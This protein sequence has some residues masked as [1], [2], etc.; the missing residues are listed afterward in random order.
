MINRR[1]QPARSIDAPHL[2]FTLV[3]LLVVIA[4]IGILIAL[5]LPAVQSAR[6]AARRAQCVNALKQIGLGMHNFH[7]ARGKFPHGA[8]SDMAPLG[9]ATQESWGCAWT[10]WVLPYIEGQS[11]YDRLLFGEDTNGAVNNNGSGWF[12]PYNYRI[13]GNTTVPVYQCPSSPITERPQSGGAFG[14]PWL[15]RD[16]MLNHFAGI[17]GFG[18]PQTGTSEFTLVGFNESRKTR[19]QFGVSSSGGILFAGGAIGARKILDGTSKTLMV[20]EQNDVLFADGGQEL[21]IGTGLGYGWLIGSNKSSPPKLT[22]PNASGDW[23]AH[24]CTTVR[25]AINQKSGWRYREEFDQP[26]SDSRLTG[27]GVIGSNIPLNSAHPGGVNALFGDGSVTFLQDS[28][29]LPVLAAIS[30]RDEGQIANHE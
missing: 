18:V 9:K 17:S 3:E 22:H 28:L 12:D 2:G 13:V 11:I 19:A 4:I 1:S 24:Q 23:R 14:D 20:S 6:E 10:V 21:K 15:P 27:V 16:I 25:Y 5:L 29:E 7:S 8:Y 26:S 30:T